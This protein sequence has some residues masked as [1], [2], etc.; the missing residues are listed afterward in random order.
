MAGTITHVATQTTHA[1]M[2]CGNTKPT[3]GH[4]CTNHNSNLALDPRSQYVGGG[5]APAK[6]DPPGFPCFVEYTDCTLCGCKHFVL[7]ATTFIPR[8]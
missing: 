6:D 7:P 1:N 4:S 2:Q 8:T 3:C 5:R